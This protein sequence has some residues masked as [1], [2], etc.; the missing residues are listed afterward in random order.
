MPDDPRGHPLSA[1]EPRLVNDPVNEPA[2]YFQSATTPPLTHAHTHTERSVQD[3]VQNRNDSGL[4]TRPLES[5]ASTAGG[6]SAC[7]P[8]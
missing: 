2:R 5:A 4:R 3:S 8:G 6:Q 1:A 7:S